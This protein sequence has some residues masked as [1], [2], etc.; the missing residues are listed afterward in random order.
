MEDV[1]VIIVNITAVLKVHVRM[2]PPGT[3]TVNGK[4][5]IVLETYVQRMAKMVHNNVQNRMQQS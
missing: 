5:A 2:V 1:R 3:N 4:M